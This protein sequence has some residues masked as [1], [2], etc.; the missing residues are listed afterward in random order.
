MAAST[1]VTA[2]EVRTW[3]NDNGYVVGVRGYLSSEVVKAFNKGRRRKYVRK[4]D[5]V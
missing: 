1:P 4:Q 2:A 3:A 5:A